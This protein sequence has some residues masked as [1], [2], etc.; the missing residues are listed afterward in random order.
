MKRGLVA[1]VTILFACGAAIAGDYIRI[2]VDSIPAGVSSFEIP[3]YI[4]HTCHD[5]EVPSIA[6]GFVLTAAGDANWSFVD[7]VPNPVTLDWFAFG[8]LLITNH[9]E[10]TSPDSFLIGGSGWPDLGLPWTEEIYLFSLFLD[11]GPGEGEILIDSALVFQ[12]GNW[13]WH[14]F[15]CGLGG[16]PDRPLFVDK[17]GSDAN[18]PIQITVFEPPCGDADASGGVDID[19]VVYLISYIFSS[20]LEPVPYESGD[21]DCSGGVDIDDVVF[22]IAYIFSGGYAPCDTDGDG[23]PDC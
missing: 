21:A 23:V 2:G 16:A 5:P 22:L 14:N 19:D 7:Y 3:F 18:H 17:Y 4:E 1:F 10:G 8:G 6:N 12:T 11:V 20:G 9:I 15:E 13:R